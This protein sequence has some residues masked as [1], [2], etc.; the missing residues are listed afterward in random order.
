[1]VRVW[2]AIL[3]ILLIALPVR[4]DEDRAYFQRTICTSAAGGAWMIAVVGGDCGCLV[5][6]YGV[7]CG[8]NRYAHY[9]RAV[10]ITQDIDAPFDYYYSGTMSDGSS[11]YVKIDIDR[12]GRF[13]RAWGQQDDGTFYE[14]T[15]Q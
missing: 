9:F 5:K 10:P 14:V 11:W 1:M 13:A 12:D 7:D 3:L 4:A 2:P 6:I 8:G 15:L